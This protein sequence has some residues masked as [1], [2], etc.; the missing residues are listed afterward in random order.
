VLEHAAFFE[1]Q[2]LEQLLALIDLLHDGEGGELAQ[3]A[4]RTP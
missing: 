1:C 2:Q 3:Q 4:C